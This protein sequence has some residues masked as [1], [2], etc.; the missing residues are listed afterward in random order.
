ML[1]LIVGFDSEIIKFPR[2][3]VALNCVISYLLKFTKKFYFLF[4]CYHFVLYQE[5]SYR[6]TKLKFTAK[7]EKFQ[8]SVDFID[9][10]SFPLNSSFVFHHSFTLNLLSQIK[11]WFLNCTFYFIFL[12]FNELESLSW[13]LCFDLSFDGHSETALQNF[14][15]LLFVWISAN[16]WK[17]MLSIQ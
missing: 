7:K 11:T 10:C 16:I 9:I 15:Y 5:M 14:K 8:F 6:V 13:N 17:S 3:C 2:C 4:Y 1:I 12:S